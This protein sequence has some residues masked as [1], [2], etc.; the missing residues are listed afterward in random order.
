MHCPDEAH[1]QALPSALPANNTL[2]FYASITVRKKF[3]ERL[4]SQVI[5]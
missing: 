3:Y 2:P 4:K 5:T 1:S